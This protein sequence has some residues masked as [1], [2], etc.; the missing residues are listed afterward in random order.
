MSESE[1]RLFL[2]LPASVEAEAALSCLAAA[3]AE[4]GKSVAALLL[5]AGEAGHDRPRAERIV[6]AAQELG[7]AALIE[8]DA[9]LAARLAADGVHVTGGARAVREARAAL[10]EGSIIGGECAGGRDAAM[11]IGEAGADYL[12]LDQRLEAGGEKMLEWWAELFVVPVVAMHPAAP[13]EMAEL[14]RRGADFACPP[15]EIWRDAQSAG[16]IVRAC[17]QALREGGAR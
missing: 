17:M 5:R 10:P 4:G 6:P 9:A 14:A 3:V 13:S 1:T 12:A 11:R 2:I 15:G 8:D 16:R 7:V